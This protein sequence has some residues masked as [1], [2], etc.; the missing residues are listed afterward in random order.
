MACTECL[1]IIKMLP[2]ATSFLTP[3]TMVSELKAKNGQTARD[4]ANS[5]HAPGNEIKKRFIKWYF[6][7]EHAAIFTSR[8]QAASKFH[9]NLTD[10]ERRIISI[11][12]TLVRA[13][14]RHT[15]QR[16]RET[17][18]QPVE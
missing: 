2:S 6:E 15:E 17:L 14:R 3:E 8:N 16:R 7:N 12:E 18:T 9:R 1:T 10:E 5:R 11:P 4:A 13:L